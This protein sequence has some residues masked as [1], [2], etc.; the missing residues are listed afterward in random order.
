[1]DE[2]LIRI[3]TRL[4]RVY[5]ELGEPAFEDAAHRAMV[6]IAR[7]VQ[8]EAERKAGLKQPELGSGVILFPTGHRHD[9]LD[10]SV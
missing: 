4:V 5:D 2:L 7:S 8:L 6:A 10:V 9:D 3:L 1:M